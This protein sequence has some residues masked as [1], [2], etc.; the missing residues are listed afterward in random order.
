MLESDANSVCPDSLKGVVPGTARVAH[1][2]GVCGSGMKALA[3]VLVA[4]GWRVSG[5]D[6]QADSSA[7]E[8]LRQRG[9]RVFVEHSASQIP[10]DVELLV[11]STAIKADNPE[12]MWAAELGVPALAY[13][14]MLGELMRNGGSVAVGTGGAPLSGGLRPSTDILQE[15][16]GDRARVASSSGGLR[17][18]LACL[19]ICIAGTHGKSTTTALTGCILTSAGLD[20]TVLVGA[21]V[22]GRNANGWAG[23]GPHLVVES[24]EYQRHFLSLRPQMAAILGIEA[25]HFDCF[26]DLE[27]TV[28]AFREFASLVPSDGLI[29]IHADCAASRAACT[30]AVAQ[31]ETFSMERGDRVAV[32]DPAGNFGE[33]KS[34]DADASGESGGLRPP[35]AC[36]WKGNS[37]DADALGE[38]GGLRP[39]LACAW[40]AVDIEKIPLGH[41]FRILHQGREFC[42]TQLRIPGRHHVLN[43]LAAAALCHRAGASPTQIAA[44]IEQFRG[45]R[46]RFEVLGDCDGV[47]LVDDY[48][49]HPTAIRATLRTAREEFGGRRLVCVFQPHQVSRTLGLIE[50]FSKSFWAADEVWIVPVYGA[51]ETYQRELIEVSTR[52]AEMVAAQGVAA[53]FSGSLDQTRASLDD[54]LRPGDVLLTLGAGDIDRIH[55]ACT[56]RLQ[57]NHSP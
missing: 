23:A 56:R 19:G 44:G 54:T 30:G 9:V 25:D 37:R 35:L 21:E 5:S 55:H 18:P 43:A 39:P 4:R 22:C 2:V 14:E 6:L 48:A 52:L 38:S 1:L 57:R 32:G 11:Y 53:R 40:R 47:T 15:F 3:E 24:C 10:A 51:R 28:Q 50:D 12:R 33:G 26:A 36:A 8:S 46:R 29:V 42:T 17:P 41:R 45:I 27:A 7:G 31:V 20:P 13:H 16:Q 34:R 49:H